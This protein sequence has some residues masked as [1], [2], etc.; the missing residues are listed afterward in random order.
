[1]VGSGGTK[2][3]SSVVITGLESTDTITC[4]KDGK[5]YP[6]TWNDTAQHWEIVGLPLGTFTITATN[7]TKTK[8]ETVLIDITGVYEIEIDYKL[9]LYKDGDPCEDVTGGWN[10]TYYEQIKAYVRN[11]YLEINSSG[12]TSGYGYIDTK[13]LV[14]ITGYTKICMEYTRPSAKN[15]FSIKTYSD[16]SR[17]NPVG[18]DTPV[19]SVTRSI[20]KSDLTSQEKTNR[21]VGVLGDNTGYVYKIWLE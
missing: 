9:W 18:H 5:I 6:A 19:S 13:N 1:M 11:G 17:N 16:S 15:T 21:I 14:D 4:T 7:G 10:A 2:N 20:F 12:G 8:T 3:I